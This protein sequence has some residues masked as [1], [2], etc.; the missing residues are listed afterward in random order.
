[1]PLLIYVFMHDPTSQSAQPFFDEDQ[2][3]RIVH[4]LAPSPALSRLI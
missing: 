3:F 2:E 1:M 4:I